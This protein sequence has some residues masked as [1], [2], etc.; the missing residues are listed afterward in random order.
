LYI[1]IFRF[2]KINPTTLSYSLP[3]GE[4]GDAAGQTEVIRTAISFYES[5][6]TPAAIAQLP[7][8]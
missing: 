8:T 2:V 4:M 5:A 1:T 3:V 7:F 6:R